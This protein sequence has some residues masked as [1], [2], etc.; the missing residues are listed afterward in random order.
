[1]TFAVSGLRLL[2]PGMPGGPA[3]WGYT[4]TD[5]HAAVDATGYFTV[6]AARGVKVGDFVFVYKSGSTEV[7]SIH[8]FITVTA[9]DVSPYASISGL[10]A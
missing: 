7:A 5:A 2:V 8:A 1:M 3:I 9:L 4:S 6:A 10:A